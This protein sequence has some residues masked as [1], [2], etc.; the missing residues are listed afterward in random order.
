MHSCDGFF[1][2][3]CLEKEK[4]M[5]L[6]WKAKRAQSSA[7]LLYF[8]LSEHIVDSMDD[9]IVEVEDFLPF[10]VDACSVHLNLLAV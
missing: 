2:C 6:S 7:F 5:R 9:V 1:L 3:K 8:T 4:K 10:A